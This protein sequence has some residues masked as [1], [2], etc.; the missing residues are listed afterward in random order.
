MLD[1]TECRLSLLKA[2][3]APLPLNGKKCLLKEWTAKGATNANEIRTWGRT[4][5]DWTNTGILTRN[6][7]AI[8]I[9]ILDPEAA[10]AVEE[11]ARDRF[12]ERGYFLVRIGKAPKR[13]ILLRTLQPF[14]KV[15]ANLIAPNGDTE[16]KIEIL[17]NGQQLVVAGIHPDTQRPY[18]W[19]GGEPGDIAHDDLPYI[20]EA[21]AR[22]LID[23]AVALLA[24]ISVPQ[25]QCQEAPRGRGRQL[26][27]LGPARRKR[28][29]RHR[30]ARQPA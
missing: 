25:A 2:G 1:P 11:L 28:A 24:R 22:A 15:T 17:G 9:D 12:E 18:A 19:H 10:E 23:D 8:D 4:Y 7:P 27:R 6:A 3:F 16:Q 5:P 14:D 13:A 30:A 21:E 26:G 29:S 20:S